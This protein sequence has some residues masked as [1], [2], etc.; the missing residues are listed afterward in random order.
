MMSVRNVTLCWRGKYQDLLAGSYENLELNYLNLNAFSR[1]QA[2]EMKGQSSVAQAG[3][4][5]KKE[6]PGLLG[7]LPG[8]GR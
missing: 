2:L 7:M 6:K 4:L 8:R 3:L 1:V 5:E